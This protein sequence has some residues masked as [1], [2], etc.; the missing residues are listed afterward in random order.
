MNRFNVFIVDTG[1]NKKISELVKSQIDLIKKYHESVYLLDTD[2][3]ILV[4]KTAPKLIGHDPIMYDTKFNNKNYYGFRLNLGLFNRPEIAMIKLNEMLRFV[5]VNMDVEELNI[6]ISKELH[7]Q[8]VHGM[9]KI[10]TEMPMEMS[11]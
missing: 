2:K 11:L 1:W 3:S 4:M 8:G 5:A 9:I 7:R 6:E 10:L